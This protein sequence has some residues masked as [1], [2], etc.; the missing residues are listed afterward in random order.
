MQVMKM[1]AF[2]VIGDNL[3]FDRL[4]SGEEEANSAE[5]PSHKL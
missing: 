4:Y 3:F 2:N 1:S 5:S